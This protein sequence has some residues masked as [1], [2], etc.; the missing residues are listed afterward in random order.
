MSHETVEAVVG[1]AVID[2][3]FRHRLLSNPSIAVQELDLTPEELRAITSIRARSLEE[4]ARKLRRWLTRPQRRQ[5]RAL[6]SRE[7]RRLRTAV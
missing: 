2:G 6:S 4:F 1:M 3:E 5:R 7:G